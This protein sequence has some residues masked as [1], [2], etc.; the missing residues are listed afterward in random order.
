MLELQIQAVIALVAVPM[1]WS[2]AFLLRRAGA[3]GSVARKLA[4][5]FAAEG[6]APRLR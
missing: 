2:F 6:I 3:P 1:C 4:L 5:L